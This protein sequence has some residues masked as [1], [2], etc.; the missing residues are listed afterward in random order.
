MDPENSYIAIAL[1]ASL[2]NLLPLKWNMLST[3]LVYCDGDANFCMN[4][5]SKRQRTRSAD[6]RVSGCLRARGWT[7]RRH[8]ASPILQLSSCG[9]TGS[10]FRESGHIFLGADRTQE[11]VQHHRSAAVIY[12]LAKF[13]YYSNLI[14]G[15][16]EAR[17]HQYRCNCRNR[18][19]FPR[20][21]EIFRIIRNYLKIPSL[22]CDE[23]YF[24]SK[25]RI[26]SELSLIYRSLVSGE[27]L[28]PSRKDNS[29]RQQA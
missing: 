19:V 21:L 15:V 6:P 12:E 14:A 8:S 28:Q 4:C 26:S 7:T 17:R 2:A 20:A 24:A 27:N 16:S 3:V 11:R 22:H 13:S 1:I 23:K 29:N 9:L 25:C 5:R 18:Q 10:S